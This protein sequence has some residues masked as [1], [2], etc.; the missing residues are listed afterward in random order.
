MGLNRTKN[1]P[2]D[3][4]SMKISRTIIDG[5]LKNEKDERYVYFLRYGVLRR[6]EGDGDILFV[7][8]S[9]NLNIMI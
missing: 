9:F 2:Y 3:Y 5:L 7:E 1:L 6:Y 8:V 4:F